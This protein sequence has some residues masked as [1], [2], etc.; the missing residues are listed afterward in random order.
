MGGLYWSGVLITGP[1]KCF[2][3]SYIS[4]LIKIRFDLIAILS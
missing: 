3:I 2:K 1:K 4:V